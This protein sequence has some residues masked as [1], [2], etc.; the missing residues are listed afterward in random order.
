MNT[1]KLNSILRSKTDISPAF[2][3]ALEAILQLE[4]YKPHQILYAA[5]HQESRIYFIDKG[6]A[7]AYFYDHS[8]QEHTI[9]FWDSGSLLFSYEGYHKAPSHYYVEIMAES[10]LFTITYAQLQ[11]LDA[12]YHEP[13][14][15]IKAFL[16][17]YQVEEF[18]KQQLVSL[19]TEERYNFTRKY[20]NS[21]FGRVPSK[22]IASYLQMS[23]ETLGRYMSKR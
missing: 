4:I 12:I 9:R 15:L 21:L 2:I 13:S 19:S 22:L 6:F 14:L 7:R 17:D 16:L 5:G 10:V 1:E 23:R 3:Q 20:N 18:Q 11:E 8:G